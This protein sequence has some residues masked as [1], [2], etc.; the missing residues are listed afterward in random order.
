M[1]S[2][3]RFTRTICLASGCSLWAAAPAMAA[4]LPAGFAEALIASGLSRPTTMAFA[5]DGRLF[6]CEQGGT[7]RVVKNGALLPAP[8]VTLSVGST[9]ERGLLGVAFDPAF[10]SNGFVYVYYTATSPIV[11]NR[12]SRFTAVGDVA[13]TNSEVVVLDL[14][15]L[16]ATN[17]NGGAI[18]FG[19]D[20]KLYVAVGEN[21]V[22]ANAQSLAT[23][24]GK[25]LRINADGTIPPDNPFYT[26]ATGANRAIWALGLRN[27]YTFAFEPVTGRMLINDVGAQ[28]WEEVNEGQPG[29]NYG[30][31]DS[32]GPTA[33]PG[34]TPPLYAYDHGA[35]CA[36][37]GGAFHNLMRAQFPLNYWGVYFIGDYCSGWIRSGSARRRSSRW[38]V[39][40]RG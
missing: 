22:G 35:G 30:W 8:F 18:H 2:L 32:E 10:Q 6:I 17:H 15:A 29:A 25:I 31:P 37:S 24:L 27:P 19:K 14:E 13:Q 38:P 3:K 16:S 7:L 33:D 12:V 5:P 34:V 9:G 28:A 26:T 11:H 4:T 21:A 39:D 40:G 23:R 1:T 20:G 36:I